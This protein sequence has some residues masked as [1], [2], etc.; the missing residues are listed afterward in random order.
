MSDKEK[1]LRSN[2]NEIK[3]KDESHLIVSEEEMSFF[4]ERKEKETD[5]NLI[6]DEIGWSPNLIKVLIFGML[7][8][9]SDGSEMVVVSLIMR[10]L[11]TKWNLSPLKKAFLG[12]SIFYGFL[13][14][15]LY[16]GSLM[17]KKGRKYT[18]VIGCIIF[19]IFGITSSFAVE[20]YSFLLFRVGVG[21]GLGFLIPATQTYLTE[22]TPQAYRGFISVIIWI[23]FPLGEMYIC[24]IAN[25]FPLD[26]ISS[27]Q[28]NW[29]IIMTLAVLPV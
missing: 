11:E 9:F 22:L 4:S 12:G 23:G 20:F 17:D 5:L 13:I 14:G 6:F 19:F 24:Y 27:H 18:F 3:Y 29:K 26:D 2:L 8:C 15:S 10:K 28:G 7:I 1:N 25:M 21:L 16:S